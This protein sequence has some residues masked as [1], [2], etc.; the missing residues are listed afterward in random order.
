MTAHRDPARRHQAIVEAACTLI[1]EVGI[2][3]LTHRMVAARAGVPLGATTYYFTTLDDLRKSAL[4]HIARINA[5]C[6]RDW[7]QALTDSSDIPATLA[8]LVIDYVADRPRALTETELYTAALRRQELRPL[9]REWT[10]GMIRLLSDHTT[11]AIARAVALLIDGAIL[12]ALST[13]LPL[14][15]TELSDTF[16]I[17]LSPPGQRL[18]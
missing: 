9:A 3:G 18:S 14:D 13:E 10:D 8:G 5:G 11:P 16:R 4:E 2:D 17:L 12:H 1:P 7:G 6:L 15:V